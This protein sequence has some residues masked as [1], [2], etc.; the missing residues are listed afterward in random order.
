[1]AIE[2]IIDRSLWD[3]EACFVDDVPERPVPQPVVADLRT[4]I[5]RATRPELLDG[6]AHVVHRIAITEPRAEVVT[7]DDDVFLSPK[8][9]A[10]RIPYTVGSIHTYVHAG[11][12][13]EG[14]HYVKKGNRTVFSWRA[15]RAWLTT[16]DKEVTTAP[17]IEPISQHTRRRTR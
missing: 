4:A 8:Q 7:T 15:M 16:T 10:K 14:V 11:K 1:M 5:D 13:V 9:L 17:V 12:L 6:L 3:S 2:V